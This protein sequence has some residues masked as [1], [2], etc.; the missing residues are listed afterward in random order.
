M[1]FLDISCVSK[2]SQ[3]RTWKGG[4]TEMSPSNAANVQQK[5]N[6]E[7]AERIKMIRGYMREKLQQFGFQAPSE[8]LKLSHRKMSS[9]RSPVKV[10]KPR[11]SELED[12]NKTQM[13]LQEE[14]NERR[15]QEYIKVRKKE[16]RL[17]NQLR[18]KDPYEELDRFR[19]KKILRGSKSVDNVKCYG[20]LMVVFNKKTPSKSK[21]KV[22]T[23]SKS[24]RT[25]KRKRRSRDKHMKKFRVGSG[26]TFRRKKS[27]SERGDTSPGYDQFYKIN[28]ETEVMLRKRLRQLSKLEREPKKGAK[29]VNYSKQFGDYLKVRYHAHHLNL[30]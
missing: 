2:L 8:P 16:I 4:A 14:E 11:D 28:K 10:T 3:T 27:A 25:L 1:D 18:N 15:L 24:L 9:R 20:S 7:K 12:P 13:M 6:Q 30:G 22:A 17:L 19:V 29:L 5:R 26:F 23:V 21:K